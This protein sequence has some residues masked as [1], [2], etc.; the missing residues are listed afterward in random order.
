MRPLQVSLV[1]VDNLL[2]GTKGMNSSDRADGILSQG[3]GLGVYFGLGQSIFGHDEVIWTY[4]SSL[5]RGIQTDTGSSDK[6]YSGYNAHDDQS[7]LPLNSKRDDEPGEEQR[8]AL[9]AGMQLF[10][11]TLI[12]PVAIRSDLA[13]SRPAA[14]LI[15]MRYILPQ[16][17]F[18]EILPQR[19]SR[20]GSRDTNAQ[21]AKISNYE[22]SNK[23]V[24]EIQN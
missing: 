20:S 22:A 14:F 8:Y 3:S 18:Q 15:K 24:N 1:L 5:D 16:K 7:K 9:D 21:R 2:M 11:N 10:R 4:H 23:Q 17:L 6:K 12:D 13:G 19:A